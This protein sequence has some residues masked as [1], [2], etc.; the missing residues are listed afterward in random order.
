MA[1]RLF[2]HPLSPYV[3]K[4]KILLYE[5][6]I[7]FRRVFVNPS[8]SGDD[9]D[10]QDFVLTSPKREVPC[11]VD[12]DVRVFDSAIMIEYIE[13]H[14]PQPAMMADDPAER[15]RVRMLEKMMDTEYEAVNWG[16]GEVRHFGR[17]TGKEAER[18]LTRAQLQLQRLWNRLALD[19]RI[20]RSSPTAGRSRWWCTGGSPSTSS[21]R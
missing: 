13:E 9:S 18:L 8:D 21:S 19:F 12:G 6:G 2:E 5:K 16:V 10:Y 1:L 17:A 3:C 15:A 11:L 14:W 4:V 20:F 7:P